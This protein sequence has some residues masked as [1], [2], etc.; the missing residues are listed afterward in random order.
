MASEVL[1]KAGRVPTGNEGGNLPAAFPT[2]WGCRPASRRCPPLEAVEDLVS[3][4]RDELALL[5]NMQVN[6]A[7]REHRGRADKA[8]AH[9]RVSPTICR[10]SRRPGEGGTVCATR[11][12][13]RVGI[14][15]FSVLSLMS[16][17]HG[18]LT[19]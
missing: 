11:G 4:M 7:D 15:C 5:A 19:A 14:A 9:R 13:G 3:W 12:A 17:S 8:H 6:D 16:V 10:D 18:C 1:K 2:N